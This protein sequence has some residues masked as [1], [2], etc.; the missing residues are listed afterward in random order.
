MI[1]TARSRVLFIAGCGPVVRRS[2]LILAISLSFLGAASASQHPD[3]SGLWIPD[4]S[5]STHQKI[6]KSTADPQS[7]PAPPPSAIRDRVPPVRITSTTHGIVAESL[8]EDGSVISSTTMTFDSAEN[9]NPRSGGA[10][11]H[12]SHST[13]NGPILKTTWS[14]E[15]ERAVVI[16]GTETRELLDPST[17]RVTTTTEDAK[18]TSLS[19]VVYHRQPKEG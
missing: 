4:F 15:R 9:V 2:R 19:V 17:L 18:S 3:L 12:R 13:W 7:S 6:L 11:A 14:I 1:A 16:F 10:L 8:A 5:R